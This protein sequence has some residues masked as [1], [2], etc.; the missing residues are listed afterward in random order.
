M[1]KT[2]IILGT[3]LLLAV[4]FV[5]SSGIAITI[6]H[7]CHHCQELAQKA[8]CSDDESCSCCSG[9]NKTDA[10]AEGHAHSHDTQY[11]FK[12]L[13]N[14]IKSDISF[15]FSWQYFQTEFENNQSDFF[16]SIFYNSLIKKYIQIPSIF[17]LQGTSLID[18]CQQRV[19]YA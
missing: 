3:F 5:F 7:C 6:H 15:P 1:K 16:V 10:D 12:I 8:S 4:F 18:Y 14:Y 9:K 13:D 11:F 17:H 19:D 2:L